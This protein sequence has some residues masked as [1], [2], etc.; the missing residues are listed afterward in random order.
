MDFYPNSDNP[1]YNSAPQPNRPGGFA[2]A[3]LVCGIISVI[4]CCT[5]VL[6]IPTGALGILFAVLTKRKGQNMS[7]LCIAG[8]WLSCVGMALGIL[9]TVYSFFM[10]FSN[11]VLY[12]E[13]NTMFQTMYGMN[14]EEYFNYI[15]NQY[16]GGMK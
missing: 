16:T 3:S 1:N 11:P 6:S 15:I 5:G 12:E 9:M 4:L 10:V 7:G 14:M 2:I 13:V 8:I